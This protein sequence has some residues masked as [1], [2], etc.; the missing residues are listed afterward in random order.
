M[1]AGMRTRGVNLGL[2][3]ATS[4]T[5]AKPGR[6]PK[7]PACSAI[8]ALQTID[9]CVDRFNQ[10]PNLAGVTGE[11]ISLSKM[12]FGQQHMNAFVAV[13]QLRYAQVARERAQ[14]IGFVARQI[15]ARAHVFDHLPYR[16]LGRV[17]EIFV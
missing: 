1:W 11:S 3:G 13:D 14:H 8:L 12:R 2:A 17:V 10:H 15:G 16:L 9:E 4:V 6:D 7:R 5:T